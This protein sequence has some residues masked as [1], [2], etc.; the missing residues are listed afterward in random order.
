MALQGGFNEAALNALSAAVRANDKVPDL[1]SALAEALQ[2]LGRFDEAISHYRRALA[3]DARNAETLY[4]Y[5]NLLL[6]LGRCEDALLTYEQALAIAPGLAEAVNNRGNAFLELGRYREA[7]AEFNRAVAMR[8]R[9]VQA[10]SNSANAA[11]RLQRF[12][13]ALASC[14][15]AL[16]ID[17]RHVTSLALRGDTY[18]ELRRFA[19]A[20]AAYERLLA[21]D[22]DYPYA[23]GR[24][25]YCR[26]LC[27]DWIDYD[28]AIAS[29]T[30]KVLVGERVAPPFMFL[31][32]VAS[33]EA[34]LRCAQTYSRDKHPA[35]PEPMWRRER[36]AHTK[37]RI[38]YLSA[39]FRHH[40][41]AYLMVGLFELHDRQRFEST[42]ISF[43]PDPRDDFRK[44]L[45]RSF[46][47]FLDAQ[48][49]SD[50]QIAL[51]LRDL[52]IDIAIDLMGY[53]NYSRPGI[54]TFRPAPI[55]VNYVGFA[56]SLGSAAIDYIIA[57]RFIIPENDRRFYS[58]EV[59]YLPDT[60]WP[61]DSGRAIETSRP[62]RSGASLP[63]SGFVFCCFNQSSKIA[64]SIFDVWMRLLRQVEGSVLWLVEDN[65]DAARNLSQE[66]E[67]RG[68]SA[69]RLVFAPRVTIE[70]YLA[71][72][73][74]ADLLLDTLPFN[75][76]T[77]ASDALWMGLPV[78]T[79]AGAG[80]AA[81]VAGSLLH[82][83]GLPELVTNS[84][85]EYEALALRLARDPGMLA[86]IRA[87]LARNRQSFPLF[88]TDRFRRHIESAYE[89]MWARYQRGEPP[90]G[91]AVDPVSARAG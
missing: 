64:P 28:R 38:A 49:S 76:H 55:Q 14:E 71:R 53:T 4:N 65:A 36:Y 23:E 85:E 89:T 8:P 44:R 7:L 52:E 74:L 57:D 67:H 31:N 5:G 45:E 46:D 59:V 20:A 83:I 40:P 26:L 70:E 35:S 1:H 11:L 43:G 21:V 34:G 84:L 77:T 81:R 75:A 87:K 10:L 88:D 9:F 41:M 51:L 16:A 22:P 66:A 68:I 29:V 54:F 33:P 63:V 82:A 17:E 32:M 2:R 18:Y 39:D 37:I 78:V 12:D 79:C 72:L 24:A 80:F 58:E 86:G 3:L 15:R 30:S 48:T 42:A 6:R 90:A 25:L 56:G 69:E 27:C 50:Y 13:E 61:T 73:P 62:I 91:F 60:Y 47:Q 19:E